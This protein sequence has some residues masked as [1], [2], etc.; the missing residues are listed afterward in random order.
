MYFKVYEMTTPLYP[1]TIV[2]INPL[3][4]P[5]IKVS[6]RPLWLCKHPE[7]KI[8]SFDPRRFICKKCDKNHIV[9]IVSQREILG[10]LSINSQKLEYKEQR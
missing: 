8:I 10:T 3:N 1:E 5:Q 7:A 6:D 2:T 4:A 9:K